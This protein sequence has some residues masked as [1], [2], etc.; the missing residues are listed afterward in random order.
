MLLLSGVLPY[1][2][3]PHDFLREAAG[4]GFP[5]I[6]I[7]RT[8]CLEQGEDRLTVQRVPP[9]VYPASYPAWFLDTGKLVASL[10][11]RYELIEAFDSFEAWDLGDVQSQA[12]GFIFRRRP[13]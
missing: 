5:F 12:R 13:G 1:L 7:D 4:L 9:E 11:P 8:P 6:L 2:E 10:A 3:A